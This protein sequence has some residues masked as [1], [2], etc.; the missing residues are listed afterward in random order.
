M[1]DVVATVAVVG[2]AVVVVTGT[3]V[4]VGAAVVDVVATVVVVGAAVVVGVAVV[5]V[6]GTVVV[7][8]DVDVV[9]TGGGV[10]SPVKQTLGTVTTLVSRVTAP[11]LCAKI[12]PATE[13]P[14]LSVTDT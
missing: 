4:E 13:A 7:G 2:A 11:P 6:I 8:V 9:T 1:V 14:V 3:V 5:V 12:R 10:T